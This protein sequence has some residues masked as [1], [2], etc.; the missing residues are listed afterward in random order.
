[1]AKSKSFLQQ[2]NWCALIRVVSLPAHRY[3][4]HASHKS[5]EYVW[6][7]RRERKREQFT[8]LFCCKL[9]AA[10]NDCCT[11]GCLFW[12]HHMNLLY[13]LLKCCLATEVLTDPSVIFVLVSALRFLGLVLR[14]LMC[15]L[16]W[17]TSLGAEWKNGILLSNKLLYV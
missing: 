1:M 11:N 5:F 14:K 16:C 6:P 15:S 8:T 10:T 3:C 13:I 17:L 4:T 12:M 2:A 9:L 7:E